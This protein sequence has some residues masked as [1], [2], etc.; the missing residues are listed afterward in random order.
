MSPAVAAR[1]PP[2]KPRHLQAHPVSAG[3]SPDNEEGAPM[4][5]LPDVVDET[6]ALEKVASGFVFTEGPLWDP[7]G[8]FYF[9]DVRDNA[10]FK[11]TLGQQPEKVR[12]TQGGNG[13][14]FD[15]QGRL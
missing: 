5:M 3:M 14:T 4:E 7:A 8:F 13:L 11:I 1:I 9:V 12:T 10:L 15:L 2:L 6:T